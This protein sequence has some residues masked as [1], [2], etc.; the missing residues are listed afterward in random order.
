MQDYLS[1]QPYLYLLTSIITNQ[2]NNP[3]GYSFAIDGEWGC[4]KTWI[5]TRMLTC[6]KLRH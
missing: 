6:R 4:G 3:L 2:S 5:L 1:R